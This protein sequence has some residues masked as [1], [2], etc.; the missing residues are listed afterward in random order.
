MAKGSTYPAGNVTG[1][2]R[3][4]GVA[5]PDPDGNGAVQLYNPA[6]LGGVG[7]QGPQGPAGPA[8]ATGPAGA[9]GAQGVAGSA[10][11]QGPAGADG[12]QGA[13][14]AGMVP[15]EYTS[16]F[17]EA[18]VSSIETAGVAWNILITD[19]GDTRSN[20][21]LPA[22]ISGDMSRHLVR[23]EPPSTWRDIGPVVGVAGP[24]GPQGSAGP[25]GAQG[26]AGP[27][28]P[29]GAAGADGAAGAQG[30]QGPTGTAGA[31]GVNGK[32]GAPD[33]YAALTEAKITAIQT[34]G[35]RWYIAV[36]SDDRANKTLP[37]SI[38]GDKTKRFLEYDAQSMTWID[39]GQWVGPDGAP[40]TDGLDGSGADGINVF[41]TAG[42]ANGVYF[43]ERKA[44]RART[45]VNT[46]AELYGGS[47]TFSYTLLVNGVDVYTKTGVANGTPFSLAGLN[48]PIA[49][50]DTVS[51]SITA[52][53]SSVTGV[54]V[55]FGE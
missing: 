37:A 10:G 1:T 16:N 34:A 23:F 5:N 45:L 32:N 44:L 6:D 20:K 13:P 30:I 11:P 40:G 33:E 9:A 47:G 22:G 7:P 55:Q 49:A 41:R 25:T 35:V 2:T 28:G 46:Y 17:N 29:Q 26:P 50:N 53:G 51:I 15:D 14:G 38:S 43:V 24:A 48:L 21:T 4:L 19:N 54:W 31:D 3:V 42:V 52:S 36:S 39:R 12:A 18:K 27:A 8:G